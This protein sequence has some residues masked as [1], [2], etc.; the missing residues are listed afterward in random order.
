MS[1]RVGVALVIYT[2]PLSDAMEKKTMQ[3]PVLV[4]D[5]LTASDLILLQDRPRCSPQQRREGIETLGGNDARRLGTTKDAP[6]VARQRRPLTHT[7][8][9]DPIS[10]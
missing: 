2:D 1:L 4:H 3:N 8:H 6:A 10:C 7:R 9:K 5:N